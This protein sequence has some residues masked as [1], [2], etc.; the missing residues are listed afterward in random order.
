[1]IAQAA[2]LPGAPRLG[3]DVA[4][5]AAREAVDDAEPGDAVLA[6]RS[7]T[8]V[9]PTFR[10]SPWSRPS[11]SP[12]SSRSGLLLRQPRPPRRRRRCL[13]GLDGARPLDVHGEGCA[14]RPCGWIR[15]GR[16]DPECDAA[17]ILANMRVPDERRGRPARPVGFA[18]PGR[19]ATPHWRWRREH[20]GAELRERG[21]QLMDWTESAD[22]RGRSRELPDGDV[23]S[24]R[25]R[26][27]DD[28]RRSP[29]DELPTSG[30]AVRSA[31]PAR[32]STSATATPRSRA[33]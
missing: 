30:C 18:Q 31:A 19:R 6:E 14:S 15:A 4:G 28:A 17:L 26:L 7:R 9:E 24:V 25:R 12:V 1:M 11:T 22:G 33:A 32:P 23:D 20:G 2:H 29:G 10:T 3:S 8:R 16:P 21:E 5:A 27:D 13:P